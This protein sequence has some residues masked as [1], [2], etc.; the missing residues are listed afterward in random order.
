MAPKTE[1]TMTPTLSESDFEARVGEDVMAEVGA[2]APAGEEELEA[3]VSR[4]VRPLSRV[5]DCDGS[6]EEGETVL[7]GVVEL[8][9]GQ[10]AKSVNTGLTI[11]VELVMNKVCVSVVT[12]PGHASMS[13]TLNQKRS[14][15]GQR[16]GKRRF[17]STYHT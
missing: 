11:T 5:D 3:V 16:E 17:S 8:E 2:R 6:R 10:V 14:G 4:A 12:E 1:P 9:L 7:M 15:A 13:Q